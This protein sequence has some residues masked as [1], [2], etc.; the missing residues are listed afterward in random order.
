MAEGTLGRKLVDGHEHVSILGETYRVRCKV[1]SI[2]GL[3]AQA[4]AHEL[5]N[6]LRHLAGGVK[7]PFVVHGEERQALVFCD[8]LRDLGV[9]GAVAPAHGQK[10]AL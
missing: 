1:R 7:Q 9:R 2:G 5:G 3:S 4:D 6:A 10:F 8:R